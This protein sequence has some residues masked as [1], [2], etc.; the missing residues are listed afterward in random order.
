MS[1][2]CVDVGVD[3]VQDAKSWGGN[4]VGLVPVGLWPADKVPWVRSGAPA[5]LGAE[6]A[7]LNLEV[8]PE[9]GVPFSSG[10]PRGGNLVEGRHK[11][12]VSAG[13]TS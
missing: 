4:G 1:V 12:V 9:V 2:L 13:L 10:R 6:G 8:D 5:L 11:K 7:R 3:T